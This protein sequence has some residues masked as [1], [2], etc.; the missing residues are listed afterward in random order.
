M[1]VGRWGDEG[2]LTVAGSAL[3]T[4]TPVTVSLAFLGPKGSFDGSAAD[5]ERLHQV[6]LR[7]ALGLAPTDLLLLFRCK[8]FARVLSL[9]RVPPAS[10]S[11]FLGAILH[12]VAQR[13]EEPM[14]RSIADRIVALVANVESKIER[15]KD[16]EKAPT[17]REPW[18]AINY[19]MSIFIPLFLPIEAPGPRPAPSSIALI[20]KSPPAFKGR[21]VHGTERYVCSH[22]ARPTPPV[23]VAPTPSASPALGDFRTGGNRTGG[24]RR[25]LN[26]SSSQQTR[27]MLDAKPLGL[28]CSRASLPVFNDRAGCTRSALVDTLRHIDTSSVSVTPGAGQTAPG[29]SL[30]ACDS[31]ALVVSK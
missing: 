2:L 18:L 15:S 27:V 13:S 26:S 9:R 6:R 20:D 12:I 16:G 28:R 8:E 5:P 22:V 19:E 29:H 14:I 7:F 31:S 17:V 30:R 4:T 11:S 24:R 3:P 10:R 1:N 21:A 23:I 25:I